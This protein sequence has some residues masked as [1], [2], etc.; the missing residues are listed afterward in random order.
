MVKRTDSLLFRI[1]LLTLSA[2]LCSVLIVGVIGISSVKTEG[3]RNTSRQLNLICDDRS[4]TLNEFL[5]SVEQSVNMIA[6]YAADNFNSL[7]LVKGG[8]VGLD[9]LGAYDP[10]LQPDQKAKSRFDDYLT[11]HTLRVLQVFKSSAGQTHGAFT[12]YYRLNPQFSSR[13]VGFWH[14][15]REEGGTLDLHLTDLSVYGNGED[16]GGSWYYVPIREGKAVWL[17][18][19]RNVSLDLTIIS[20]AA[21]V[22]KAGT[23]IGVVGMDINWDTLVKQAAD[24]RVFDSG[25]AYLAEE[26]GRIL[27]HPLGEIGGLKEDYRPEQT[28]IAEM[29]MGSEGSGENT[30][31]YSFRG[32]EKEMAFNTLANGMKLVV[33]A[34][35][36]ELNAGWHS[37]IREIVSAGVTVLVIFG[38][39]IAYAMGK[40]IDPLTRLTEASRLLAAG[41]YDVELDYRG[42]DEVGVLT[43]AFQKLTAHLRMYISDLNSRAYRD[44]LTGVR[45]KGAFDI[46]VRKLNDSAQNRD[47]GGA[48]RFAAVMFDCD[49]LKKINDICGHDKGDV[50]L[51]TACRLICRV[52]CHSPVFR[53]GGDEFVALLQGDEYEKREQLLETFDREAGSLNAGAAKLWE[54]VRISRGMAVHEAETDESA[55][56]VLARA[57]ALMY[58]NKK[59]RRAEREGGKEADHG[60]PLQA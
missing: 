21:P 9:G 16:P 8:A 29:L 48:L 5:K 3:D 50:Y 38:A 40:V 36:A 54:Q 31:V 25:Y 58:E 43:E 7:E 49:E 47:E 24:I 17:D 10:A 15:L 14:E 1:V 28:P 2:I 57:D 12:Y 4:K 37:M 45:N 46:Y 35:S 52:F 51:Q 44:A 18:P 60:D 59:R 27:W 30:I 32:E 34:P 42:Q 23:F 13:P 22:Y 19:Y 53:V 26:D 41:N 11:E 33:V 20:Y 39:A 56:D 55:E 6:A